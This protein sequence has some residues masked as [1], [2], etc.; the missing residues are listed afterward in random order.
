MTVGCGET[1][2]DQAPVSED[3]T[4][5]VQ[6]EPAAEQETAATSEQTAET[7]AETYEIIR[8]LV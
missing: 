2:A 8:K 7:A 1:V 6:A 3:K 4:E 5:S